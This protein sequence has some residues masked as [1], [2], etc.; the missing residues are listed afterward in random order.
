MTKI[1][2]P[3]G[4]DIITKEWQLPQK[5]YIKKQEN[6]YSKIKYKIHYFLKKIVNVKSTNKTAKYI[7]S[8]NFLGKTKFVYYKSRDNDLVRIK[9]FLDFIKFDQIK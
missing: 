3:L 9:F 5:E 1:A 4:S 2:L 8:I 6:K 7:A